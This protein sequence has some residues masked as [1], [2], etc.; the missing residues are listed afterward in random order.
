MYNVHSHNRHRCGQMRRLWPKAFALVAK[1]G[2][3]QLYL[4]LKLQVYS[5]LHATS[6]QRQSI[7]GAS[8]YPLTSTMPHT[9]THRSMRPAHTHLARNSPH[10][11]KHTNPARKLWIHRSNHKSGEKCKLNKIKSYLLNIYNIWF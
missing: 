4:F 6:K 1:T 10:Q 8:A 11:S 5:A 3:L 9:H 7:K 2:V